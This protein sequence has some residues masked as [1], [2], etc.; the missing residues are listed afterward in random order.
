MPSLN[1][2]APFADLTSGVLDNWI[3]FS[4]SDI[5]YGVSE[6]AWPILAAH[7]AGVVIAAKFPSAFMMLK[8]VWRRSVWS[9]KGD[10]NYSRVN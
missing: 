5:A 4:G 6:N 7:L 2:R 3:P 1:T 8:Y 9:I 10:E